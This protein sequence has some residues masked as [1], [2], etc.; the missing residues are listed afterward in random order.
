M[1]N[2]YIQYNIW[3]NGRHMSKSRSGKDLIAKKKKNNVHRCLHYYT[4]K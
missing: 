3:K 4:R 2:I 1:Q